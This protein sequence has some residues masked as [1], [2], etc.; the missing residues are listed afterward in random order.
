MRLV[1]RSLSGH[2]SL[3]GRWLARWRP[4]SD[5]STLVDVSMDSALGRSALGISHGAV[6]AWHESGLLRVATRCFGGT[7][8]ETRVRL[9]GWS[10]VVAPVARAIMSPTTLMGSRVGLVLWLATLALGA[11]IFVGAAPISRAWTNWH[12]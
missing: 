5:F 2:A 1:F 9:I 8:T 7:T 3:M 6:A 12:R 11:V 4:P 10:V